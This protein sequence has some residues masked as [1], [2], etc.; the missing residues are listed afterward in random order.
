MSSTESCSDERVSVWI[1]TVCCK[2]GIVT[3]V[4]I[5]AGTKVSIGKLGGFLGRAPVE[6]RWEYS[7][8]GARV[9]REMRT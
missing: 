4:A 6:L 8:S 5:S 1:Y 7:E 9:V 2:D 3:R